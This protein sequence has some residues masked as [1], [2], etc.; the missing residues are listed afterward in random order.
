MRAGGVDGLAREVQRLVEVRAV[1]AGGRAGGLE[2]TWK[3]RKLWKFFAK[4][5]CIL[6]AVAPNASG[7]CERRARARSLARVKLGTAQAGGA[8]E[9]L[10][11]RGSENRGGAAAAG[12]GQGSRPAREL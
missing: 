2:R 9:K 4:S 7:D 1:A 3:C 6:S 11:Q 12:E 10:S 8:T 5:L